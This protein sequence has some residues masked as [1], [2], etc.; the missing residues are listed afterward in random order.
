MGLFRSFLEKIR[1]DS[2][3]MM[4]KLIVESL[5]QNQQENSDS[6]LRCEIFEISLNMRFQIIHKDH[7]HKYGIKIRDI[8]NGNLKIRATENGNLQSGSMDQRKTHNISSV[9]MD[10]SQ[11]MQILLAKLG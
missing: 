9:Q 2:V 7:S 1:Q 5:F 3:D 8:E 4:E 6:V 11:I 10:M